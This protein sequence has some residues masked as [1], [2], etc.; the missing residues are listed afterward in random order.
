MLLLFFQLQYY[1]LFKKMWCLR[2]ETSEKGGVV[3][4]TCDPLA[5]G[6]DYFGVCRVSSTPSHLSGV[7]C[8]RYRLKGD[9]GG[10]ADVAGKCATELISK[11]RTNPETFNTKF[12]FFMYLINS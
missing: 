7:R 8:I 2:E 9:G 12:I 5:G 6:M 10:G 11:N 3:E 4:D 1:F